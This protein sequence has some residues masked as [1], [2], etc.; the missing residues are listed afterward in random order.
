[1]RVCITLVVACTGLISVITAAPFQSQQYRSSSTAVSEARSV[2]HDIDILPQLA[3]NLAKN[4]LFPA[5]RKH[6][7]TGEPLHG[8]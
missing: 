3:S 5:A 7:E 8:R 4:T 1:M 6:L 2:D